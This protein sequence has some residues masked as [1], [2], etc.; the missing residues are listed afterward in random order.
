M[1]FLNFQRNF[2]EVV[3]KYYLRAETKSHCLFVHKRFSRNLIL[4]KMYTLRSCTVLIIFHQ[5]PGK[6]VMLKKD[7]DF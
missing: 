6:S 5:I 1:G 4:H 2:F 3:K 7:S